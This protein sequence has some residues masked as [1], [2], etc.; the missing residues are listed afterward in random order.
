MVIATQQCQRC[1]D[2]AFLWKS[3]LMTLGGK[4]PLG[5]VLL[6]FDLLMAG[7]S[8]SKVLQVFKHMGISRGVRGS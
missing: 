3:Q 6:K 2:D 7:A 8:I 5:N 1:S 4:H